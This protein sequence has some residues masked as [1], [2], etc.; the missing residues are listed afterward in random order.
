M[1]DELGRVYE[2]L[3]AAA[4]LA[5][6]NRTLEARVDEQ[7]K[8]FEHLEPVSSWRQMPSVGGSSAISTTAHNS[9]SR[10]CRSLR[11][12]RDLADSHPEK[13]KALLEGLDGRSKQRWTGFATSRTGSTHHSF[14]IGGSQTRSRR[15][16][17][18]PIAARV[19]APN[20]GRYPPDVEATVYSAA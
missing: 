7:V 9:T 18:A 20:L 16:R 15:Q 13:A 12:A 10:A 14:R 17:C 2:Q 3:V 1:N 19:Q 5:G 11:L 4:E 8:S 6:W